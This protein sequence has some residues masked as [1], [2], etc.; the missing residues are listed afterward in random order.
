METKL[1]A[2]T[3]QRTKTSERMMEKSKV[4]QNGTAFLPGEI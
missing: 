4:Q 3:W 2:L 1:L